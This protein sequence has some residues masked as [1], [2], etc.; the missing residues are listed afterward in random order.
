LSPLSLLPMPVASTLLT[1]LSAGL[2]AV[3]LRVFL[4]AA[5]PPAGRSTTAAWRTV[6]WLLPAAL[7]LEPVRNTIS[8][9]QVNVLL[10]A[11]VAADCLV[12]GGRWPRGAL[13]GLAAAG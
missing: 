7:V 13:V 1:L 12:P 5:W 11:L 4:A 9:G 2:A 3:V 6:G 8:Y 10:M